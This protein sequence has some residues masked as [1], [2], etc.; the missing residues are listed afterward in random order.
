M[1][2][3]DIVLFLGALLVAAVALAVVQKFAPYER[4]SQYNDVA[5]FVFAAVAGLYA[6][7][8]AFVVVTVWDNIAES[9]KAT[10][11]EA[12]CL[13]GL[14][15]ISR[16]MPVETGAPLERLTLEYAHRVIE[17]EW[18]LMAWHRSDPEA[19]RMMYEMRRRT[20]DWS[21]PGSDVRDEV[22]YD[23]ALSHVEGLASG[24]RERLSAIRNAVPPLLWLALIG[25]GAITVGFCLVFGISNRRL[26]LVMVLCLT[27]LIAFSLIA[28]LEM[29]YPF[30]G[31]ARVGPL[32]F[33]V[34]LDR[35]P[36]PR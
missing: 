25:G 34:F 29:D 27:A 18:P 28:I 14:Y 3:W 36:P 6:V 1:S 35:L 20:L 11:E 9:R 22:R 32:A 13:A 17:V 24:R 21:P 23:H 4:R 31:V 30:N 7:L 2:W 8:L 19:T 16:E 12:D 33:D 10:F 26:H 15:W 5:S